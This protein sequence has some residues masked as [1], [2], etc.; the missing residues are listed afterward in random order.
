[1][2]GAYQLFF[3]R[4]LRPILAVL[5]RWVGLSMA[6]FLLMAGVT[7]SLLAWNDELDAFIRPDLFLATPPTPEA[8]MLDPFILRGLVQ[9]AYPTSLAAV[10]PFQRE[11]GH[12]SIFR[13]YPR[14]D[15]ATGKAGAS[16]ADQVF[17]NPYTGAI[18]GDRKWGD[19]TQGT[20]NL[21]PFIYRLHYSLAL[22][23][24]GSYVFG[25]VALLWTLDCFVGAC[26]TFPAR[27]KKR[28]RSAKEVIQSPIREAS[29]L[30]RWWSSWLIRWHGGS[31][32]VNFDLHRA[33]GLWLWMMMLVLAWSSVSFNLPEVYNPVMKGLFAVQPDSRDVNSMV[34]PKLQPVLDWQDAHRVGRTLMAQQAHQHGFQILHEDILMH[35]SRKNI[36]RYDVK[37]DRDIRTEGGNTRITFDADSGALRS[38]WLPTG[39]AAGDTIRMWLTSL[40]MAEVWGLPMKIFICLTGLGTAL[41]SVTGFIIWWKKRRAKMVAL[42]RVTELKNAI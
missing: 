1:M 2:T 4:P 3:K 26:L 17:V 31:Y 5:H 33:G 15:P 29:W 16:V 19:L 34:L 13:I 6:G 40:H 21:M 28:I 22:G 24:I 39:A 14:H 11:A 23:V 7:G 9:D 25:V 18:L 20:K 35:D 38:V 8:K 30:R 41:L 32:K 10:V 12:S 37:S 27:R 42:R 36:Y